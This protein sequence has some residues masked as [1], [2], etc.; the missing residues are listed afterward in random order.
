MHR[1]WL[2]IVMLL[3]LSLAGHA[4]AQVV[5]TGAAP[6]SA[7]VPPETAPTSDAIPD[8]SSDL[9]QSQKPAPD[10]AGTTWGQTVNPLPDALSPGTDPLTTEGKP[11][12]VK[13]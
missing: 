7:G 2:I 8:H 5:T 10:N 11:S 4:S 1:R 3:V 6:P 13:D 12:E 9:Y